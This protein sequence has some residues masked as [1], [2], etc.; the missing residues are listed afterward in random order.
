MNVFFPHKQAVVSQEI[1]ARE[2]SF[3]KLF[4]CMKSFHPGAGGGER[5]AW[6]AH[7][8]KWA[9]VPSLWLYDPET[10]WL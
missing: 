9:G 2:L 3:R 6:V 10:V 4:H 7:N 5:N 1:M 8:Q